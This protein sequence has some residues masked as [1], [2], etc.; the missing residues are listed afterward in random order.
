MTEAE[1]VEHV[2]SVFDRYWAIV[3]W[4]AS[5]SFSLILVAYFAAARLSGRIVAILL[6][7]YGLY[8]VWV[9]LLLQYNIDIAIG[10]ISD[11]RVIEDSVGLQSAGAREVLTS[12]VS[13]L[14]TQLGTASLTCTFLA[15]SYYLVHAF[16]R[17]A[18]SG[19]RGSGA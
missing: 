19:G 15:C 3:Q 2:F 18:S 17:E 1:L 4:W 6:L 8:S 14:G 12:R 13:L 9:Y 11:L 10:L 5:I 16:R 7:L